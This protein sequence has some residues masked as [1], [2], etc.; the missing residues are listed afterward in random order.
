VVRRVEVDH[1]L[2]QSAS[3]TSRVRAPC[4]SLPDMTLG[5]CLVTTYITMRNM[6][7]GAFAL[8]IICTLLLSL[9]KLRRTSLISI[10]PEC[11]QMEWSSA[12]QR[13]ILQMHAQSFPDVVV[14]LVVRPR[15]RLAVIA[16]GA[17][18]TGS[19]LQTELAREI[20]SAHG[21]VPTIFIW[22]FHL[23]ELESGATIEHANQ[24]L[25][26]IRNAT[27]GINAED[28]VII[29]SHMFDSRL[30]HYCHRQI[31]LTTSRDPIAV[32]RSVKHA[33]WATKPQDILPILLNALYA[34]RCWRPF[35]QY[36]QI[37]EEI[38]LD[39]Y[40]HDLDSIF[41]RV[42]RQTRLP[43]RIVS[44][45]AMKYKAKEANPNVPGLKFNQTASES[46]EFTESEED[47]IRTSVSAHVESQEQP[48]QP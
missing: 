45:I 18:R 32:A 13:G 46:F 20:L 39:Q 28:V 19:T 33:G 44:E 24:T 25:Q 31:V 3:P 14:P 22:N 30:L 48:F 8:F 37:Y 26:Q 21:I 16:A 7:I 11:L 35:S 42:L 4:G 1:K 27:V 12:I 47:F 34:Q 23:Y 15:C 2:R 36:H 6:K 43:P 40:T 17:E 5:K 9:Y 29:K 10:P 41:S 38:N